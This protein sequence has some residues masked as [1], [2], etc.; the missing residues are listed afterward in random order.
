M[1]PQKTESMTAAEFQAYLKKDKSA[2]DSKFGAVPCRNSDGEKFRSKVELRY[3]GKLKVLMHIGEV[4]KVEREVRYEFT[5]NGVLVGAYLL[6][7]R[8]TYADGRVDHVDT[9]SKPTLTPLFRIKQ[10]LMLACHD[11]EVR[12]EFE[13]E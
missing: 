7:F 8:V 6:D 13:E 1:K 11:I 2:R 3:A 10:A 5:V 9:K 4:V 12:A